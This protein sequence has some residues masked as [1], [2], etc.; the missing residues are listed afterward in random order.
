MVSLRSC[1]HVVA[2]SQ[3]VA[4]TKLERDISSANAFVARPRK[5]LGGQ[6]LTEN[7]P[8]CC[9]VLS[10]CMMLKNGCML[11]ARYILVYHDMI[12][13][14][15]CVKPFL[16]HANNDTSETWKIQFLCQHWDHVCFF[17][18]TSHRCYHWQTCM[19]RMT[20]AFA[21]VLIAPRST[22]TVN[23]GKLHSASPSMTK[24]RCTVE[25][26]SVLKNSEASTVSTRL[27]TE[28]WAES[29]WHDPHRYRRCGDFDPVFELCRYAYAC[30]S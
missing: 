17:R 22:C 7:L 9:V 18:I 24:E 11:L 14:M 29:L 21:W 1:Q 26:R 25:D 30:R 12:L 5:S 27:W 10:S 8:H 23:V 13:W 16:F 20:Q 3:G 19:T 28:T 6:Q 4:S 2:N 15:M